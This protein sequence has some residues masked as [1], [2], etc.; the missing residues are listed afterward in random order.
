MMPFACSI[1]I[2]LVKRRAEL[3]VD[4]R[5][6]DRR[7]VLQDGDGGDV[8]ERLG[9][10]HVVVA[11]RSALGAEQV[12]GPD[13]VAAQPHRDGIGAE[14]AGGDRDGREVGHRSCAVVR[15]WLTMGR[16]L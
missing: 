3:G 14:E 10:G 1:T 11:E 12:E 2:R 16:P 15:S 6:H 4:L 8:G 7:A 5:S 13:H 9:D